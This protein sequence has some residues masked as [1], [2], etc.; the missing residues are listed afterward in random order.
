MMKANRPAKMGWLSPAS[1]LLKV[2]TMLHRLKNWNLQRFCLLIA[3]AAAATAVPLTANAA[4]PQELPL[5]PGAAPGSENIDEAEAVVDRGAGKGYVDRSISQVHRPTVTVHLPA[6]AKP[7]AAIV[8]CPGGGLSRVVIDKEGNDVAKLLNEHGVAGIVL[9]YR[10]AESKARFYGVEAATADVQRAIRLTRAQA[11]EWN[12]DPQRVGVLG[13]SAGGLVASY[14][15]THFDSG[16]RRALDPV[17]RES[18]RPDFA[19]LVYPLISLRSEV[20]GDRYQ[21]TALGKEPT[22]RQIRQYSSELHVTKET[23][24]VFL[25]HAEDDKAVS[26]SNTRQFAAACQDAG[27]SCTTFIRAQGG[28]GY[29]IRDQGDPINAWPT[30]FVAWLQERGLAE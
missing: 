13:F 6:A 24:P 30:A 8:I 3:M 22:P 14:A 25:A 12:I 20:S 2:P 18:C 17:E 11:A 29:G 9:K 16:Q 15:A 7:T 4:G 5:W 28:H 10:T 1:R 27:V 26:V 21:K 23:P 19:G